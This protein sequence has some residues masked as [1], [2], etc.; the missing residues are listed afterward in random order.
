MMNALSVAIACQQRRT[1]SKL[2]SGTV[3]KV[4]KLNFAWIYSM[5]QCYLPVF[6]LGTNLYLTTVQRNLFTWISP[7]TKSIEGIFRFLPVILLILYGKF[8]FLS[9]LFNFEIVGAMVVWLNASSFQII[10]PRRLTATGRC[11]K[12]NYLIRPLL[13]MLFCTALPFWHCVTLKN[14]GN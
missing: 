3:A 8:A 2:V 13:F 12:Y 6:R 5:K 1:F 11:A 14:R 10:F 7:V 9:A 4:A